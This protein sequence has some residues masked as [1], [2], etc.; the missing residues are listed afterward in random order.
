MKRKSTNDKDPPDPTSDDHKAKQVFSPRRTRDAPAPR[1]ILDPSAGA[2]SK[3]YGEAMVVPEGIVGSHT[4]K[5][6]AS[7]G[8]L[9]KP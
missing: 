4:R 9:P 1:R 6:K 2:H 8:G 5:A 7:S 3:T